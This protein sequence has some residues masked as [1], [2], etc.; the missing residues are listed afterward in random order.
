MS[1]PWLWSFILTQQTDDRL[2]RHNMNY[3]LLNVLKYKQND[4]AFFHFISLRM[5]CCCCFFDFDKWWRLLALK[6]DHNMFWLGSDRIV[7][8]PL[9]SSMVC[10]FQNLHLKFIFFFHN[11]NSKDEPKTE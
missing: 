5:I 4:F 2:G 9:H 6:L 10:L 8:S 7:Q 3:S 11:N 1:D